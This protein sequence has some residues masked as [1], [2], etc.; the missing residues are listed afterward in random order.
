MKPAPRARRRGT[1]ALA[2]L[3]A[4][5]VVAATAA[6]WAQRTLLDTERFVAVAG[7]VVDEPAVTEPLADAV[8]AAVVDALRVDRLPAGAARTLEAELGR[9]TGEALAADPVRAHLRGLVTSAHA[10]TVGLARGEGDEHAGVALAAEGLV[11]ETRPAV[12]DA[13]EVVVQ[14]LGPVG[15]LLPELV[16]PEGVGRVVL[17]PTGA[18]DG[19]RGFVRGVDS[20]VPLLLAGAATGVVLTVALAGRRRRALAVLGLAVAVVAALAA[21]GSVPLR[22]AAVAGVTDPGL[23]RALRALVEPLGADLTGTLLLAAALGA[24][25]AVLAAALA[26]L[27][28][29][30]R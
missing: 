10:G 26:A 4:L 14:D 28:R 6:V 8:S 7:P 21:L 17:V 20:A 12:V 19:V 16:V 5:L 29:R 25:V 13:I 23:R 15:R 2:V 18:L 24:G 1:G 27:G 9:L 30:Q 22:D 11:L 3:T